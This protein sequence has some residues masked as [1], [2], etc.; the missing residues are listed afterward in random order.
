MWSSWPWV[1]TMPRILS[2]FFSIKVKSGMTRST[3]SMSSSGKA[4][5]QSTMTMSSWH[6]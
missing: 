2:R 4:M 5:P 3:P 1:M 6:S